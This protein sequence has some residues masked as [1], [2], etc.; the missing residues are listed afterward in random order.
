VRRLAT[1]AALAVLGALATVGPPGQVVT[2]AS[3]A[4]GDRLRVASFNVLGVSASTTGSLKSWKERRSA[5][6][7]T[8][9]GD[10]PDV[11]GVQEVNPSTYW[12]PKLVSG[13]NQYYDLRNGLN[14][15]GGNYRLTNAYG[16]NCVNAAT[17]NK[18]VRKYRGASGAQRILYN[19][20]RISLVSQG[21]VKYARQAGDKDPR[22]LAW[23]VLKQRSSGK[24]FLFVNT[25]L[26][27]EPESVLLAQW[28]QLRSWVADHAEGRPVVVVGDF[29]TSKWN[30]TA[31]EM[32]PAMKRAG[33]GDVLGQEYRVLRPDPLRARSIVDSGWVWSYNEGSKN[34]RN[35]S[36]YED[37][38][39]PGKGI[40][41]IFATNSLPVSEYEVVLKFD[42]SILQVQGNLPSD[43]NMV[44][45]D[46]LL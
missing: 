19:A 2:T 11:I 25:H 34:V 39:V 17:M 43:H 44:R 40:D 5:V 6:V 13:D 7:A 36:Y 30:T 45:A 21:S 16:F 20:D 22:Y 24:K 27:N 42:R 15:A 8:I 18:C 46:L 35:Y 12:E 3:A 28:K 14:R 41:W 23:A 32:L 37:R 26:A 38:D 10:K 31:R 29:N 9:M 33:F 1:A 4:G